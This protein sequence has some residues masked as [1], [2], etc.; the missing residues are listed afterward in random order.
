MAHS[1]LAV[2]VAAL[3]PY[4]RA[5]WE[6]YDPAWTSRDPAFTHAHITLL[7]PFL[8]APSAADLDRVAEIARTTPAFD[9]RLAEVAAFPDGI[10]HAVPEPSG[11]F[12]ELTA[13]LWRAFP[14]CPPYEGEFADTVPHLTLD[15]LGPEVSVASVEA[16]LARV[17]PVTVR[18]DRIELHWYEE[19]NCR[20]LLGWS[21]GR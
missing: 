8:A 10:V 9:F 6:H 20:F 19:M 13:R 12:A 16:D 5:R 7:A 11:P 3:E 4:V 2:P 17:L 18:A 21:C 14:Q 1:V 15:R